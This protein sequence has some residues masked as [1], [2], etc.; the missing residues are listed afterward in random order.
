[1]ALDMSAGSVTV[2]FKASYNAP[3]LGILSTIVANPS[4]V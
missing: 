4:I 1:M 3:P 2:A